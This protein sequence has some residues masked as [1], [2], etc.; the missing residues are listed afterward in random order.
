MLRS[1]VRNARLWVLSAISMLAVADSG[2]AQGI[3]VQGV[4]PVNRSMAGASTAAPIDAA[5]A[6]HWNPATISGLPHN[7]VTFGLELLLPDETLFSTLGPASGSTDAESGVAPI[8]TVAWVQHAEDDRITYGLGMFGV[9]G[10]RANYPASLT[11][12]ISTPQSNTPGVPGGLGRIF[13]ELEVLQ[14]VPTVSFAVTDRLSIGFAP[15]VSLARI[16]AQPLFLVEPD[17]ADGSGQPRYPDGLGNRYH[18]GFGGQLGIYY[19]ADGGWHWGA[20]IKS[21][22]WFEEF[23]FMTTDEIGGP[24]LETVNIDY[25]MILSL[26]VAYSG[27]ERWVIAVDARYFDYKNTDGFRTTGFRPDFASVLGLGWNNIFS[28]STGVQYEY[29]ERLTLRGGYTY[30]QVPFSS[31]RTIFN[32]ASPL[33]IEH[34]ASV[35]ASYQWNRHVAFNVAYVHGFENSVTGPIEQPTTGPIPGSSVTSRVAAYAL[36]VGATVRY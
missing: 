23:R 17:D 11:N 13:S 9:A 15:T 4:G 21:P 33:I 3:A 18:W 30:Q 36:S 16:G 35:G 24:R 2:W 27:I 20:S 5:G 6:I 14:I 29:S 7:E 31:S 26:G 19:I 28:V 34:V 25:P 8:P 22:Q 32:V 10:Y 1:F 12:P